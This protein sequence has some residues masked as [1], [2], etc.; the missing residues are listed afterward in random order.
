M[1]GDVDACA[2]VVLGSGIWGKDLDSVIDARN[3][4]NG[5]V[6]VACSALSD[7]HR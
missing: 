2:G 3:S 4:E 1:V 5:F 6:G 7:G